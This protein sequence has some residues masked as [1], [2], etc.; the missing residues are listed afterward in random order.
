MYGGHIDGVGPRYC[1]SIEDKVVRF[2]DK[3]S[4]QIFLEP[5]S[6][7]ERH[8]LSQRHLHVASGRCS[9][10]TTSDSINGLEEARDSAAGLCDRIRLCRSPGA[11]GTLAVRDVP[12]LYLAG[13]INGTTGYEE[14]AAQGLVAGLNAAPAMRCEDPRYL[15]QVEQL[16]WRDDRRSDHARV[17]E[18]YRMFTSGQSS[19]FRFAPTTRTS[20]LP[21]AASKL[22]ASVRSA[23]GRL[24]KRWKSS[25]ARVRDWKQPHTRL[26]SWRSSAAK[27]TTMERAGMA[28][29]FC[30][31][32]RLL[33]GILS[34]LTRI[35]RTSRVIFVISW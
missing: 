21:P 10:A 16:H 12:G 1:P 29:R 24:K 19:G 7:D 9:G 34:N 35:W 11:D 5:E 26:S 2:A 25:K 32:R 13:Q 28:F 14:A 33:S 31:C 23:G 8:D 4:H 17:T 30:H 3:S 15:Q 18:P 27:S 20:A 6:L 22:G